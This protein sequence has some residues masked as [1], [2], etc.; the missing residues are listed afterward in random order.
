M[1]RRSANA[2]LIVILPL[3]A[4]ACAVGPDYKRPAAIVP[5][6][7]KEAAGWTVAQP[8]DAVDRGPWWS[9]YAD[10]TLD[11]LERQVDISNQTLKASEAAYRQA[12]AVV[13]EG[14]SGYLPTLS[15]TPSAQL[16]KSASSGGGSGSKPHGQLAVEAQADWDLDVWG[17]IR[18]TVES[19]AANAQA[20]AADLAVARLSAQATLAID[21]FELRAADE[22]KRL[23]DDTI[24]AYRRSLHIARNQYAAGIVAKSDV[25]QAET[26][27]QQAE[28]QGIDLGVQRAALEHAIALLVGK[29][30]AD[31]SLAPAALATDVPVA[32]AGLPS[33]LLQ[34][35]PDIAEA[36]RTM[37]AANAQIGVATAAF[38]PDIT[39]SGAVGFGSAAF[40]NLFSASAL[41]WSVGASVAETLFDGGLRQAQVASAQA[42]YDQSVANYRQTVLASFQQVEDQLAALRILEQE[43]SVQD[44]AVQSS[45]QAAQLALNEY[46]AG[47]IAYTTVVT[48]QAAELSSERSALTV[49]QNRLTASVALI[50]AL[51]GG[52]TADKLPSREAVARS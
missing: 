43:A 38:Y 8:A 11:A 27:L 37:A 21:Y 29:A 46:K 28:A 14:K 41:A 20:S 42:T 2:L 24:A 26:Q 15:L 22:N 1:R 39:L 35:R 7:Y 33:T 23:Y 45:R 13:Q 16:S 32:P 18:R 51:G 6:S 47:T 3:F 31:L 17:R 52:W 10:P 34:R 25:A 49:R 50:E 9:V 30:P 48:A 5:A 44:A 4:G 40:G 36:E 19:D 12:L